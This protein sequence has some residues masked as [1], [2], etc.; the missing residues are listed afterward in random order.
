MY[1]CLVANSPRSQDPGEPID[2]T[3]AS[4]QGLDPLAAVL[5]HIL[6][7]AAPAGMSREQAILACERDPESVEDRVAVEGALTTLV[8][9]GLVDRDGSLL[10]ATRAAIRA[11]QLR[12]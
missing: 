7:S 6:V 2:S 3:A 9:D 1:F 5:L 12:F 10:T 8:R 11:D 4:R